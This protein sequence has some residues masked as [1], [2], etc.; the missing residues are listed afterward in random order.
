MDRPLTLGQTYTDL[1]G[2]GLDL[3]V[4]GNLGNRSEVRRYH[5]QQEKVSNGS[6]DWYFSLFPKVNDDISNVSMTYLDTTGL[7]GNEEEKLAIYYST[8]DGLG[9]R[10]LPST[11][12]T[13]TNKSSSTKRI[14]INN[15]TRIT[16]SEDSCDV[17]PYVNIRQDTFP[18]CSGTSIYL[19]ADSVGDLDVSWSNSVTGVD[20][21][22][23]N[24]PGMYWVKVVSDGGC[25]NYD[26]CYVISAPD[27]EPGFYAAPHCLG[28]SAVFNDTSKIASGTI[29]Y[30]WD[31]GDP[32]SQLDTSSDTLPKYLYTKFGTFT[33]KVSLTSNYG[34]KKTITRAV[35][36]R[37]I[38]TSKFT[39][40]GACQDSLISFSNA[41]T[42]SG[43]AGLT[44]KWRFGDGDTSV[45]KN[46]NHAYNKDTIFQVKLI[47][48]AQGCLDSTTKNITVFPNPRPKF[49]FNNVCPKELVK[50]VDSSN[51]N[52]GTMTYFYDLGNNTTSVQSSPSATYNTTG[53][54]AI[55][56]RVTSD[57]NC[58]SSFRDTLLVHAAPIASFSATNACASDSTQFV[59]NSSISLGTFISNWQFGDGSSSIAAAPK[60]AY[61]TAQTF[62]SKLRIVSDSGCA[63]STTRSIQVYPN[64]VAA[65]TSS[66]ACEGDLVAF[67]NGSSI[68]S[69]TLSYKW[70]FGN[71]DTS[72]IKSPSSVYP[73]SGTQNVLL[74]AT[75]VNN[76][77]DS[78]TTPIIVNPKPVVNL[79]STIATCG[80]SLEIDAGN[81]GSTYFWSN[82][83]RTQKITVAVSGPYQVTV[84]NAQQCSR[85]DTV[86][87]TLNTA[88]KVNLGADQVVCDSVVLN[89]GYGATSSTA[90][91]NTSSSSHQLTVKSTGI[92]SVLVTDPNNCSASD[93]I[94]VTVNTSPNLDLGADIVACA[95]SLVNLT[96]NVSVAQYKWSTGATTNQITPSKTGTYKLTVTDAN[97][98]QDIDEVQVTFNPLPTFDLG[99]AREAC[100]STTLEINL[101]N[102]SKLWKGGS[103]ASKRT[104]MNSDTIWATTTS[105]LGCDF[106][107]T[108]VIIIN[109]SPQIELG[110]DSTL[111]FQN[112]LNLDAGYPGSKYKWSTNDT[113][114]NV[115]I[116]SSQKV[117]VTVTDTSSCN[118]VDSII[119]TIQPEFKVDLGVDEPLC[120]NSSKTISPQIEKAQYEWASFDGFTSTDSVVTLTDTGVYWV[121]ITDTAGC[122][123]Q[124]TIELLYTDKEIHA[125]FTSADEILTGDTVAFLNLSY[126]EPDKQTWI[127]HDGYTSVSQ[128]VFYPFFEAGEY[129]VKL[130]VS[131]SQCSDTLTKKLTVKLRTRQEEHLA[132]ELTT[133]IQIE[134]LKLYPNPTRDVLNIELELSDEGNAMIEM[135]DLFGRLYKVE[136]LNGAFF[137]L[138]YN[139]NNNAPGMYFIRASTGKNNKTAKFIKVN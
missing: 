138:Q 66:K 131:N 14:T 114:Q 15:K 90:L 85:F 78:L 103:T 26:T 105:A 124:D 118:G 86:N 60:H 1:H 69:G 133:Y 19:P 75:S 28:D 20:S 95:D 108:V 61:A 87:V 72:I 130:A 6:N 97:A 17:L 99:A 71:G 48:N 10:D 33:A 58:V 51:I 30:K 135:Y 88:V 7:N 77:N 134:S 104:V 53:S 34:C 35:V 52:S 55:S 16:L 23:V 59:N 120:L 126:P 125:D 100:D 62:T 122:L 82:G 106:K 39:A 113:A 47:A 5:R 129:N 3:T 98:C 41:S 110:N 57:K 136:K 68:S 115:T 74:V 46:P 45:V 83:K 96:S 9:W 49:V 123:A 109:N 18:L 139:L 36:V 65:F 27:P 137:Q 43:S 21:I 24:S 70:Y 76:C 37:P 4:S 94:N 2:T 107:D 111:C 73:T 11:V 40:N 102:A 22:L 119:V 56:L 128:H 25:V 31:F 93:T 13:N 89:S 112:A 121:R 79:G 63:D 44:Y 92:Y 54:Y 42:I 12:D 29:T 8:D 116:A 32:F 127:M 38:P 81:V 50:F 64:P 117:L 67:T 91:W 84:T 80:N 132:E 101:L